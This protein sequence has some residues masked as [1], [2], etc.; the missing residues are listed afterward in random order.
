MN[1]RLVKS[2]IIRNIFSFRFLFV[3]IIGYILTYIELHS[4]N[5]WE[6]IG[7]ENFL[8]YT[9]IFDRIGLVTMYFLMG[10]PFI[11]SLVGGSLYGQEVRSN[12]NLF[13]LARLSKKHMSFHFP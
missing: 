11:A 7:K 3:I 13:H 8:L 6:E 9:M 2:Q 5:R 4:T 1:L 10:L 12:R